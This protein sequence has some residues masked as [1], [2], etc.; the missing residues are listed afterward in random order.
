MTA[1][2]IDIVSDT[3][4]PWCYIGKRRL[5]AALRER[6]EIAA[7]VRWHPYQLAPELPA[8][9]M[10]RDAYLAAKFGAL[11]DA[12][13][14][15]ARIAEAGRGA[16]LDFAFEKITRAP[17]TLDSHRLILWAGGAGCQDAVV[18]D[19]FRAYFC[20]GRD[21][22]DRGVLVEIAGRHG[23]D[24]MLVARLLDEGRDRERVAQEATAARQAG[25]NG[26]PTFIFDQRYAVSGAQD[27]PV[28][29]GILDRVLAAR[30]QAAPAG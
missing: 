29:L 28:L 17:N 18:E 13:A 9:G 25:I 20:E 5:E 4:C 21:I 15:F 14:I 23:M 1:L 7:A 12:R 27:A 30:T 10:A 22:G 19:L 3:V 26:V 16:G 8:D 2:A 11:A 6:T 24:A